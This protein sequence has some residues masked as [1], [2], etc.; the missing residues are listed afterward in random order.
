[1]PRGL[2]T[3]SK[4]SKSRHAKKRTKRNP[5]TIVH[6]PKSLKLHQPM[7]D[8]YWCW[9]RHQSQ[10]LI[11]IF[12]GAGAIY[13]WGYQGNNPWLPLNTHGG[14]T[15]S[16]PSPVVSV[17]TQQP[18]GLKNLLYNA[19]TATGLYQTGRV[20]KVR[21]KITYYPQA[22]S[23]Q[24]LCCMAPVIG[25]SA[26]YTLSSNMMDGPHG[27][28]WIASAYNT[29]KLNSH[30]F[31][32]DIKEILALTHEEMSGNNL[33]TFT[34]STAPT[35]AN[36]VN[37]LNIVQTLDQVI[38]NN[39]IPVVLELEYYVEFFNRCDTQILDA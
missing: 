1:M 3:K 32:Y 11:P 25:S 39:T 6:V 17:N 23:D 10:G 35:S 28:G 34:Y 27:V 8:Q 20:W 22:L 21:G 24:V 18:S 16:M 12:G 36:Q 31:Q 4:K 37:I 33:N 26:A 9:L 7:P 2:Y 15:N 13:S 29:S 19:T 38:T 14:A 30:S 5:M